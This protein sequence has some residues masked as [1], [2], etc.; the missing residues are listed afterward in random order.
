MM[1]KTETELFR[2]AQIHY[3]QSKDE[4]LVMTKD[5]NH[6]HYWKVVTHNQACWH[7]PW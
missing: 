1:E 2:E 5:S 7:A 4:E 3:L 6:I